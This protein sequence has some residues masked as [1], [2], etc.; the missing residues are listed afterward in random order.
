MAVKVHSIDS[1]KPCDII[2]SYTHGTGL[3]GVS[4]KKDQFPD[5]FVFA[6]VSSEVSE[7]MPLIVWSQDSD[8]AQACDRNDHIIRVRSM[9][10]LLDALAIAPESQQMIE[11]LELRTD[12]F[13]AAL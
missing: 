13:L 4:G 8:F 1:V 2:S 10:Q 7:Q 6:A 12:L 11:P 9:C 5:A 3:F